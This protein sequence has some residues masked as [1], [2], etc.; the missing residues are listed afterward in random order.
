MIYTV[1]NK[2]L[3]ISV[4]TAGAQLQSIYSKDTK[5]EYLWQGDTA[6]WGGRAYNLFPFIGRMYKNKYTYDGKE[7]TCRTHGVARY[8]LFRVEARSATKLVMLLTDNEDTLA[9]YP[10]HF[11][12]RV[13]FEIK[14]NS[15]TVT[16]E[17]TNTDDRTLI[18]AFGGH[19]GINIPFD[20]GSFEEYYVE[21]SEKTNVQ[22]HLFSD[23]SPLMAGKSVPYALESGLRLHFEHDLFDNDAV[24]LSNTSRHFTY[25]SSQSNRSVNVHFEDFKYVGFWHP[26]KTDAPFVCFEPWTALAAT[27][28]VQDALE[29]KADMTHVLP[30]QSAKVSYTVEICE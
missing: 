23:V 3:R 17:V 2:K 24:V 6:Y 22:R 12:Y 30:R 1:E 13:I 7:Y 15:L 9:E 25:K 26:G 4:D 5:T 10:F 14:D 20:G 18:C 19:P 28:G 27:E 8:A 21:F 16:Q 11:E 29:S